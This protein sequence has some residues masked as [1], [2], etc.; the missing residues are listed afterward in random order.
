MQIGELAQ[1]AQCTVETVRFYEKEGLLPEPPRTAGNYRSYAEAQLQRLCF[2]RTCRGLDMTHG[3]IRSLLGLM[4]Q[5]GSD[6][7]AVN[8]LLDEHI[9]H[10]DRRIAE[11]QGLKG[12]LRDLRQ[13]C[14]G[15]QEVSA[16]GIMNGLAAMGLTAGPKAGPESSACPRHPSHQP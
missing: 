14:R 7:G 16:C 12:Q 3:E 11:L 9:G 15:E 6:C 13:R 4:D 5:P 8:R 2:I 1:A 10:V